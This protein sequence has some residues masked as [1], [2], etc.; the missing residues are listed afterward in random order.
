MP[1]RH[2]PP[3]YL[4][5]F[6][7]RLWN[8]A[9]PGFWGTAIFLSVVGL[10]IKEYWVQPDLT[11]RQENKVDTNKA[12]NS[13]LTPED[14]AIAA[15]I[16]N[17]PLLV[18]DSVPANLPIVKN[19]KQ[20]PANKNKTL[21]ERLNTQTQTSASNNK[22]KSE[23]TSG[24]SASTN[25]IEN[26]FLEQAETLLK[27][28]NFRDAS[29]PTSSQS[30]VGQTSLGL[31]TGFNNGID[32]RQNTPQESS[33]QT[34]LNKST[35][36]NQISQ[37]NTT[38][39]QV[40]PFNSLTSPISSTSV[41]NLNPSNGWIGGGSNSPPGLGY[42]QPPLTN[43]Q[44]NS[45][46]GKTGSTQS[47]INQPSNLNFGSGYNI[48]PGIVTQPQN[49]NL[50]T[51]YA[52]QA[53][54]GLLPQNSLPGTNY[55]QPLPVNQLQNTIPSTGYVQ[56]GMTNQPQINQMPNSTSSSV[57]YTQP[58]QLYQPQ[59]F[60]T[61]RD[62]RRLADFVDLTRRRNGYGSVNSSPA[63]PNVSQQTPSIPSA[64]APVP[65]YNSVPNQGNANTYAN[66]TVPNYGSSG[67]Q[68]SIPQYNYSSP[69]QIPGQ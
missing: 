3:A 64:P 25:K 19:P 40:N 8:L 37:V 27:F 15:D 50:G 2:Y 63:L 44:Q 5:Y 43:Q 41:Q 20:N 13:S 26:P 24:N 62:D 38:S 59:S 30:S 28:S 69:G 39:T 23:D 31:G 60:Y 58:T 55:T 18:D 17:L 65:Y 12:T 33:L 54:T 49:V 52:Q 32:V 56:P 4:R 34:A 66:P 57:N 14:K 47:T 16:D 42:T 10:V 53:Q 22:S 46:Y 45:I 67:W 29:Q 6:K 48:Q 35:N 1:Q 36:Q 11:N 61:N 68:Q 9:R 21:L 7:A 51:G